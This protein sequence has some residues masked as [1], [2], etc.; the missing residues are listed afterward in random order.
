MVLELKN[1]QENQNSLFDR[2]EIR[3]DVEL[4]ITPNREEVLKTLSKNFSCP[5]DTI[6]IIRIDSNFGTKVF[7]IVADIYKSKDAKDAIVIKRKK[8]LESENKVA[9]ESVPL[10]QVGPEE[11]VKEVSAPKGV[12]PID[13]AGGKET[14]EVP[15]EEVKEGK[16]K[17]QEDS[18]S[19]ANKEKKE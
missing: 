19:V 16:E 1:I 7:T 18:P 2:K 15:S 9:P 17:A 4:E 11:E 14:K 10:D 13:E 8:E 6:N 3:A 12:P 5:E